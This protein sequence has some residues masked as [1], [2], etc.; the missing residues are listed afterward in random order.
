[1]MTCQI[2][3]THFDDFSTALPHSVG[4]QA[5]FGCLEHLDQNYYPGFRKWFW[6][7]VTN[8]VFHDTRHIFTATYMGQIVGLAIAKRGEEKKLCT[9]WVREDFRD[10][11]LASDLAE[12]AFLW[13]GTNKPLFTIPEEK[14]PLFKGLL[15]KWSFENVTAY[16]GYYRSNKLEYVFNGSL[17]PEIT[18]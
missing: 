3:E 4:M 10:F 12:Q 11:N 17:S 18:S 14:M 15:N 13:I 9:L 5:V 16:K 6:D 8:D 2:A 7:K 1:M